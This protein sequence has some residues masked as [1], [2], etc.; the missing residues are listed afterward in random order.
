MKRFWLIGMAGLAGVGLLAGC[1][2]HSSAAAAGESAAVAVPQFSA[3]KGLLLPETTRLAL[4][5]KMA[6]VAER[7]IASALEVSLRVYQV[8]GGVG[9]ASGMV[10]PGEAKRL[11]KGQAVEM[12]VGDK[13]VTGK[14]VRVSDELLRATGLA[15]VL[16]E[17]PDAGEGLAVGAFVQGR[18]PRESSESVV[19]IPRAALLGCS[20][21]QFVYTVSGEHLV[22]TAVKTGAGNPDWVEITDGLY[23]GDQVVAE[24][25]MSLWLTELAAIK[26]GQACCAEPPKGK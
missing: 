18:V 14:V 24:P 25:V 4:G 2:A 26:G 15:E 1:G 21:G 3:K 11:Q 19:T 9:L 22:R 16:V 10:A 12:R 23:A 7:K 5:L 17:I 6:E 20:E 8:A 13:A